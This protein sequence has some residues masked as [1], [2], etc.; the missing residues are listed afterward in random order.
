MNVTELPGALRSTTW[1]GVLAW[2]QPNRL[3]ETTAYIS[4]EWEVTVR[5]SDGRCVTRPYPPGVYGQ[6]CTRQWP[7]LAAALAELGYEVVA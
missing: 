2:T 7:S 5:L 4:T 6:D 3:S 1:A